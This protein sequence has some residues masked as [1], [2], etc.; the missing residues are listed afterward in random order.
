MIPVSRLLACLVQPGHL[1]ATKIYFFLRG[2]H[3]Y[4][5]CM[6]VNWRL[7]MDDA[8]TGLFKECCGCLGSRHGRKSRPSSVSEEVFTILLVSAAGLSAAGIMQ[9]FAQLTRICFLL[10]MR[11]DSITQL[12]YRR[13]ASYRQLLYAG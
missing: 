4:A 10:I 2:V 1:L 7:S 11:R 3:P 6:G 12:F 5:E 8:T 9:L 13:R